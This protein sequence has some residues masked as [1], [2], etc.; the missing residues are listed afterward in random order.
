MSVHGF[1]G[2]ASDAPVP[3]LLQ[4]LNGEKPAN[5]APIPI[6]ADGV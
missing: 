5:S 4:I 2:Y 1:T 3:S 6:A